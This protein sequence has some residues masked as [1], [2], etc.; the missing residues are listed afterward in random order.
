METSKLRPSESTIRYS[1]TI[2]P[3][4]VVSGQ[5]DVYRNACPGSIVGCSP[6]TPGPAH[7]LLPAFGVGDPPMALHE[8]HRLVAEIGDFNGIAPEIAALVRV[9]ALRLEGRLDG[10]F[11]PMR[12]SLVHETDILAPPAAPST[13]SL[14]VPGAARA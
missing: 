6:T 2:M 10:D 13:V 5:P 14:A 3:L 1:P 12:D 11:D 8:R 4:G 7:L 9:G